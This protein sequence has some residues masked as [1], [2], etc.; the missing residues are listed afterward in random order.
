MWHCFFRLMAINDKITTP[1]QQEE[2]D[3]VYLTLAGHCHHPHSFAAHRPLGGVLPHTQWKHRC[4]QLGYHFVFSDCGRR[5]GGG[6]ELTQVC[7]EG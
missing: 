4:P 2:D 3:V 6:R 1:I 7:D 5:A